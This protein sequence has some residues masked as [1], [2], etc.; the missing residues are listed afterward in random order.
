MIIT[1]LFTETLTDS[2]LGD[3]L[4]TVG[5]VLSSGPP[6]GDIWWAQEINT[7]ITDNETSF[8]SFLYIFLK[9]FLLGSV[10]K[11]GMVNLGW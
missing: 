5:L 2:V 10:F 6:L 3:E 11:G 7:V 1:G 9:Y 8:N 4:V